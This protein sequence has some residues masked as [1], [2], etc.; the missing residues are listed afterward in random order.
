[1]PNTEG[2]FVTIPWDD[3][4]RDNFYMDF[5]KIFFNET[6]IIVSSDHNN[7]GMQRSRV[8]AFKGT[9]PITEE[10]SKLQAVAYLKVVQQADSSVV[11]S[12]ELTPSIYTAKT[13]NL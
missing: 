6:E 11:A 5:S 2:Q 12:F 13:G 1:M 9:V 3:G 4:T 7:S 10:E 8:L